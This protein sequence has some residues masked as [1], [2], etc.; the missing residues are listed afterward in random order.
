MSWFERIK[1]RFKK[2]T[3]VAISDRTITAKPLR[4]F[5]YLDEVSLRSLL[6]S[7][8]G[9]IT[10]STS[11]EN[12]ESFEDESRG[13]ASIGAVSIGKIE[14][15][16]RFQTRNSSTLQTAKKATV[17]SWFLELDQIDQIR[18]VETVQEVQSFTNLQQITSCSDSSV[19]IEAKKL[20]RGELVEFRVR[21]S[22]DPIFHLVTL[23]AEFK[24]M[25]EDY[26]DMVAANG[27]LKQFNKIEG[28]TRILQRLLAGLIPVRAELLDYVAVD[29]KG[30]EY[31]THVDAVKELDLQRKPVEIVC[32]T[33][34]DAY[35]KDIRRVL[36]S[37]SEF[38]MLCRV[39][40]SGL[41]EKWTPIK[42]ADLLS[43]F[44]PE[45][46]DQLDSAMRFMTDPHNIGRSQV[47]VND[48]AKQALSIYANAFCS[49][50]EAEITEQQSAEI[51]SMISTLEVV[52]HSVI[53]QKNAFKETG[54][55][56]SEITGETISPEKDLELREHARIEA[57]LPY[58]N[59]SIYGTSATQSTGVAGKPDAK[60]F[61]DVEAVAMYW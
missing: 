39:S 6:S 57:N 17:Q 54:R 12:A 26:P 41:Q 11:K 15:T 7:K 25:A 21:L 1:N 27:G 13:S 45:L 49:E 2:E 23:I 34:L 3:L 10:D 38:T 60:R 33:E 31:L 59:S 20:E 16:S 9:E 28:I 61:L 37:N 44:V 35:W 56:I 46:S 4:E 50:I 43:G 42:L 19:S 30:V 5:V 53:S 48:R 24:G 40:R 51:E 32:V 14:S 47:D 52:D 55:F 36:F 58:L 8:K 29:I 22:A 18:T